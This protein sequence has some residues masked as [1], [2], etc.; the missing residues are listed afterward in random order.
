MHNLFSRRDFVKSAAIT[1]LGLGVGAI[2]VQARTSIKESKPLIEEKGM[3][4]LFQGDSLTDG[5]RGRNMDLNHIMGHGYAFSVASRIGADFPEKGWSFFNR[6]ISGNTV[7]DLQERWTKD[8]L[9]LQPDLLSVLVGINDVGQHVR[10]PENGPQFEV[11]ENAYRDILT[12]SL[13][14]NPEL[15]I[16]MGMPFVYPIGKRIEHWDTYEKDVLRR[17]E[18]VTSL[19]KEFDALLVDYPAAFDKAMER[20]DPEYWVW[21]GVHPTVAG[22]EIMTKAWLETVAEKFPFLKVY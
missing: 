1:G 16:V 18:M 5:N 19:A 14:Q 9:E 12:Q 22:H 8:A 4:V 11:F 21:D 20:A 6:G 3:R 2:P 15:I 10:N 7:T 17:Q 13:A